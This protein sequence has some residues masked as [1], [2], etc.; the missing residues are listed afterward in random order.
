MKHY[1]DTETG[2]IW[3]FEN[4]LDL[5]TYKNRNVPKTLVEN[6]KEKP[7]GEFYWHNADWVNINDLPD[8]YKEPASSVP[9]Y[10][11]AWVT[12]LF[13]VGTFVWPDSKPLLEISLEQVNSNNYQ[14]SMFQ[15]VATTIKLS[16]SE[17]PALITH[18]GSLALPMCTTFPDASVA[19]NK[20]NNIE[21]TIFL[22]GL[23]LS[24]TSH[25]TIECGSLSEI[26]QRVHSN[27]VST[28]NRFRSNSASLSERT[29]LLHPNYIM[30]SDLNSAFSIGGQVLKHIGNLSPNFLVKG[31]NALV[32][33][34]LPDALSNLWISVE[35][36]TSY[37]W[38]NKITSNLKGLE[39][40]ISKEYYQLKKSKQDWK[41]SERHDLLKKAGYISKP[42]FD[43]LG[44]ARQRRNELA[45]NGSLPEFEVVESLWFA[46]ISL[47][48]EH[49]KV[50][51]EKLRQ[52]T[53]LGDGKFN[54]HFPP[55]FSEEQ[56]ITRAKF[57][58][59]PLEE[60]NKQ[61]L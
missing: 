32:T 2:K 39:N 51:L 13:P 61:E 21:G 38:E 45:H 12:F 56:N 55:D 26:G 15:E 8:G 58:E 54:K 60:R 17:L 10:N 27:I 28:H 41:V 4:S 5:I 29:A 47:I 19:L 1:Q 49:S 35:Q 48:E 50:S 14:G 52:C 6:V 16:N 42:N 46:L 20:I 44:K 23:I 9:I 18:D 57:P 30:V 40:S 31:H 43:V 34:D 53:S 37:L 3:A 7:S 11:P 22:G 24:P 25:K 36:I 33:W 59:W